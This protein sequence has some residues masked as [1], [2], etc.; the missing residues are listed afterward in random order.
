MNLSSPGYLGH[1]ALWAATP[2]TWHPVGS[3]MRSKG[4]EGKIKDREEVL[5]LVSVTGRGPRCTKHV[6]GVTSEPRGER[7]GEH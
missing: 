3:G 2:A 5:L 4:R 1:H 7:M 6:I